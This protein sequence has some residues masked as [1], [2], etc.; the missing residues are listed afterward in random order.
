MTDPQYCHLK[1]AGFELTVLGRQFPDSH[2]VWD[3]N[4]LNVVCNCQDARL[5]LKATGPFLTVGE[6][7]DLL[8]KLKQANEG[9]ISF[10]R[11]EI[12]EPELN[13]FLSVTSD[14]QV[15]LQADLQPEDKRQSERFEFKLNQAEILAAIEQCQIILQTYPM[16]GI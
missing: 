8:D 1:L 9:E 2:D 5:K 10:A 3:G 16:R 4:W 11:V 12:I 14:K 15:L 13:L 6:I 7:M